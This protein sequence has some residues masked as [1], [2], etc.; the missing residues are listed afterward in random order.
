MDFDPAPPRR[1]HETFLTIFLTG[2]AALGFLTFLILISGGYFIFL[3]AV[4]LSI[5]VFAFLH[6][7][8]WGHALSEEVAG[9][10]EEDEAHSEAGAD[11]WFL[12]GPGR[13]SRRF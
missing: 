3:V 6:Y 9:E 5:G 12:D 13:H 4:G 11:D 1:P 2:L 8:L 7:L 10:R